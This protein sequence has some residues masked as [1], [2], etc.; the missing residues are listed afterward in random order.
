MFR[1]GS[2]HLLFFLFMTA[3]C[4]GGRHI[5]RGACVV[6]RID[7]AGKTLLALPGIH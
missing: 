7:G 6:D 1:C 3:P 2:I 5:L 4:K